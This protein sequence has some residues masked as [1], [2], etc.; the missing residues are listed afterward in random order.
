MNAQL[1]QI[2]I[3]SY[4]D[5]MTSFMHAHP[6]VF[7]EAVELSLT[8]EQPLSWRA[9]WLLWDCMEE[10]D[11]RIKKH[12]KRIIEAI[13]SKKDG[14]QREL[15]K[16]LLKVELNDKHE[17]VLFDICMNLWEDLS[18]SPSIRVTAFKF[19]L[20]TAQKH[21]DLLKEIKFLT[22]DHYIETLS[23]GIKNSVSRM[24]KEIKL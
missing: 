23:P 15:I 18:K 1:E 14:H 24:I 6:E 7:E 8:D 21:P 9:A 10:N 17:G 16:I 19:I 20:K 22:Q 12:L 13:V 3:G 4:K 11:P 2:L 5:E